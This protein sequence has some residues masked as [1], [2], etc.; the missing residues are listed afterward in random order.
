M[1]ITTNVKKILIVSGTL[2]ALA[3]LA[4]FA[5]PPAVKAALYIISLLSPF[6]AGFAISR[7]INPVAD[8]LQKKLKLPRFVSVVLVIIATLA[9]ISVVVGLVGYKLVDE[10]KNLY[11]QW[12][13]IFDNLQH[14]WERFAL[15]W[16]RLYFDMPY[17]V[18]LAIDNF[19]DNFTTEFGKF[20][21]NIQV[22]N[23]AQDFAKSLPG[24]I[25]WTVIFILSLF[26]MVSQQKAI[27]NRIR[28][29]LGPKLMARF[30]DFRNECRT[31]LGGY[32]KAQIILMFIIFVILAVVLTLLSAP[33]S[34]VVA[35]ATAI[36]DALPVFGSG[37]T[38]LP[39]SVIYFIYGN[40]KLG[41]G[42]LILWIAVIIFRRFLEPKLVSDRMG[43]NPLLTLVSMYIGYRWWGIIG[44]LIGP[45]L[46]MV[47]VSFYSVGIFDRLI[48]ITKQLFN[49]TVR[50]IKLFAQYL[51][52]ITK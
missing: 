51:D 43:L 1:K 41:F 44:M 2:A 31:Y 40:L 9:V 22:I 42:Y 37:V 47:I 28:I 30:R 32:V 19:S 25:I 21:S 39:L 36:L 18:K 48:K 12:P 49:F 50:E 8:K 13:S 38:L 4:F 20:T 15:K 7:L 45:I 5:G 11:A 10:I 17:S 23:N 33:F 52:N 27:D 29:M 34:L 24:G 3:L 26:F 16:N 6:I 46:L 14:S 35:A